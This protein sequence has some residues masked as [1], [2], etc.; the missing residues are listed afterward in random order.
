VHR[1]PAS[2]EDGWRRMAPGAGGIEIGQVTGTTTHSK[3][4]T[5]RRRRLRRTWHNGRSQQRQ[6]REQMTTQCVQAA[7]AR[8]GTGE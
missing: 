3:E 1:A 5:R 8:E 6:Q 7:R 2:C 4:G